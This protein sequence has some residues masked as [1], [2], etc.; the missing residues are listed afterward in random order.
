MRITTRRWAWGGAV[1][2]CFLLLLSLAAACG[3]S[4]SPTPKPSPTLAAKAAI[5]ADW[6]RFFAGTTP[7]AAKIA[8]LQDGSSFAATIKAQVSSSL[9]KST[10]AKVSAVS[11]T[12]PTTAAVS[13]S[14]VM[15]GQTALPNQSGQ[16]VL[17]GGI[18]KV[19][20]ASF[21][22][23]LKLE[24]GAASSPSASP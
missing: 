11:I 17:I 13:Y 8:L 24:Q 19:S 20:A 3:F 5:T 18:W 9:A 7:A 15:G 21:E 1:G 2:A 10:A 23:L 22:A 16:A 6:Q 4:S 14:I 12:S